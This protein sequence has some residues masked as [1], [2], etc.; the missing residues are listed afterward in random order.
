MHF[1]YV[2]AVMLSLLDHYIIANN[3]LAKNSYLMT[4]YNFLYHKVCIK[5]QS[6]ISHKNVF[7][8]ST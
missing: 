8:I 4:E 5:I 7:S 3:F 6:T 1:V 2:K